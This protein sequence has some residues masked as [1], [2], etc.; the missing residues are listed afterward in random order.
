MYFDL[1]FILNCT[2]KI[3]LS[4]LSGFIL[5]IERKS[6]NQYVGSRTLVLISVSSTLLTIASAHMADIQALFGTGGGDPTRIAAGLVSGIGFLG[7]GAIMR[8]GLNVKG[9]T[10]AAVIWTA[11]ALGLAI[12]AGLYTVSV[13]VVISILLLLFILEKFEAKIFPFGRTK[14]LHLCFE[15]ENLDIEA[16]KKAVNSQGYI[17]C[18]LNLSRVISSGTIIL[19]YTV[20][21][22]L[23]NDYDSFI[24]ELK[25]FGNLTEFSITD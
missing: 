2:I 6:R 23:N 19:H 21:P 15:S 18:D 8:Q 20:K 4:T 11:S 25:K 3:L 7:G 24:T 13:I 10:S 9:L 17:V 14:T 22:P 16:V 5:G 12:G 1:Q